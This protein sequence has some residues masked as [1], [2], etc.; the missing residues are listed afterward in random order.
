[1]YEDVTE[2]SSFHREIVSRSGAKHDPIN[3]DCVPIGDIVHGFGV[4]DYMKFTSEKTTE[5][6]LAA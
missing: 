1:V 6:S 5:F 2:W 3:V 4:P